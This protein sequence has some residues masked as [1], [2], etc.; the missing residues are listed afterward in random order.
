M[1][2]LVD[3][4]TGP[5]K[6]VAGAISTMQ[7]RLRANNQR[8]DEMRGRMVET[9][10][11]GYG[12]YR[13]IKAPVMAAVEFESAMADVRKVV[14]FPTPDA[15]KQMSADIVAMSTRI[16]IA[17][18]GIA[19]IVAAAG[20]AAM[21][22]NE[23]LQFT[24][25]A[26]KVGVAFDMTS[27]DV[28]EALAKIKTQL[29]LS[30]ADTGA[31]AD[32]INHLSNTSASSAPD[33][34][35]FMKRVAATGEQF[36]FTSTQTAAI[37]SA[38]IA[39]GA[40][41]EVAA[42]SFRNVGRALAKGETA[43]D[44]LSEA[45]ESLGLDAVD[46]AKRFN[47]DAVG[48]LRDVITRINKLPDHMKANA[49]S[50]I[51]GDEAR[52]LAPL[53][54]N[55][56]LYDNALKS[57][58]D[59]ASYLG[60]A[61]KEFEA[62][63]ATTANAMQL[64]QNKATAAGIAIGSALLPALND[65]M[66]RLGPIVMAVARF[67]EANPKL[68]QSI[69]ALTAGFVGL[70]VAAMAAQFSFFWMRGAYLG[71]ALR[72]LKSLASAMAFMGFKGKQTYQVFSKLDQVTDTAKKASQASQAM[73]AG[74]SRSQSASQIAAA[75]ANATAATRMIQGM[76]AAGAA[77]API[78][79]GLSWPIL[80]IGAA[81]GVAAILIRRYWEPISNFFEGF[82]EV[83]GAALSNAATEVG[84]FGMKVAEALGVEQFVQ[85]ALNAINEFGAM[86]MDAFRAVG[87]WISDVFANIWAVEDFSGA[88]ESEFRSAGQRA[89]TAFLNMVTAVPSKIAANFQN[90]ASLI[91]GQ[92]GIIDFFERFQ[93]PV[94][95]I[96]AWFQGLGS[97]IMSAI[98]TIDLASLVKWPSMPGWMGSQAVGKGHAGNDPMKPIMPGDSSAALLGSGAAR[99]EG[100]ATG[101]PVTAGMPFT[102][103]ER[104]REI[105]V[106]PVN[107][108][109][110]NARD[111][112][113]LVRSSRQSGAGQGGGG[114]VSVTFGN[115]I[116]QGG[117][118][119]SAA[120]IRREFSR[121]AGI[122]LR[123][124]FTDGIY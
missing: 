78:L 52:A 51:F 95:R 24:E 46:V 98:G 94:E 110:I 63:A 69:I 116:V 90:L 30:V 47:K 11:V 67:A 108:H 118:N 89:A 115:I 21:A 33:I 31:L 55:I 120:D 106:P 121:E 84:N 32:A 18:T 45:F 81:L 79:A 23:L 102:V 1:L 43:T 97:R 20:Q 22:G 28:G 17:A 87:T 114:P 107:G 34:V 111:T 2:S 112:N 35:N 49:L 96:L 117:S 119:A 53:V 75:A 5:A 19:D 44:R 82:G 62:R 59:Q 88:A 105:F 9:A 122:L 4:V 70:R 14:D 91:V 65:L 16:P 29:Q 38:M 66:D 39:A 109:I 57:V 27:A 85:P 123:S 26:A 60:S 3:K 74:M 54:T 92:I 103:G 25:I 124:H 40:E 8:L 71:A 86:V 73:I 15:F 13:A 77:A 100:R 56:E 10:A 113:A 64:F 7:D 48:T 76:S 61:Q 58:A 101:G 41:A 93:N 83:I 36:G 42:T 68:T 72:G 104:G 37:G 12:L 80:A 50:E 6:G 99:M